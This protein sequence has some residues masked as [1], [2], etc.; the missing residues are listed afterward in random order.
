MSKNAA[1]VSKQKI[2]NKKEKWQM[3]VKKISR[4]DEDFL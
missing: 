2:R 3:E 1:I 4:K